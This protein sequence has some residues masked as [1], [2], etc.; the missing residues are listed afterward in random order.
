MFMATLG[1]MA[2]VAT[3][4]SAASAPMES[5]AL[6]MHG[7][8]RQ[9]N[10]QHNSYGT[11]FSGILGAQDIYCGTSLSHACEGMTEGGIA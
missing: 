4:S 9:I 7:G 8:I 1:Q 5:A 11:S 6:V 3:T 10:P 2:L